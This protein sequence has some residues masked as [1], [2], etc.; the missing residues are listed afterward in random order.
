MK[1]LVAIDGSKNSLRAAKYALQLVEALREGGSITLISVHDDTALRHARRFVGK[2]AV[3][4]YLREL[5]EED[6]GEA[7][8]LLEKAG[9]EHE[10]LILTGQV[11]GAIAKAADDGKFDLLVLGSKGRGGLKDL[12]IGSVA[13][14]VSEIS[15]VPVLLVK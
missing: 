15:K 2:Q 7:R 12:L 5:S 11:A 8:K 3:T 13:R 9:R 14:R 4:D 10:T 1:L 6:L